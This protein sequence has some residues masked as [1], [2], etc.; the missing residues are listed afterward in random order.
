[1]KKKRNPIYDIAVMKV[2][3]RK[4]KENKRLKKE[5]RDGQNIVQVQPM[6]SSGDEPQADKTK[7]TV[8][9]GTSSTPA[10]TPT[11][12]NPQRPLMK[13]QSKDSGFS[14]RSQESSKSSG[15]KREVKRQESQENLRTPHDAEDRSVQS[16]DTTRGHTN[17]GYEE[18][19][20]GPEDV[21]CQGFKG[22]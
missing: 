10:S 14:N 7:L 1:M 15:S 22:V 21:S 11:S 17:Q 6:D 16:S 12:S 3:T 19:A 4:F 18:D 13:K 20:N 5:S 8:N 9:T 2:T